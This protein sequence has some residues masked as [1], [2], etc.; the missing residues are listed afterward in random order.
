[1]KDDQIKD[2]FVFDEADL[3]ANRNGQLSEKQ[4][5]RVK[6]AD[7]FAERVIFILFFIFL[8]GGIFVGALAF[9][10][11]NNIGLWIGTIT[12][13]LL[14]AW[15]Y[16]G[17]GTEVDDTVQNVQGEVNFVKVETKTGSMTAPAAQR[18]T[19]SDYEMW[20]GSEVFNNV[21]PA[22]IEVMDG[23]DYTVYFT[24]ITRQILSIEKMSN[25]A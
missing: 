8:I 3:F 14:A 15:C 5:K 6:E 23:K 25:G 1:M 12:L 13:L 9:Y 20:V 4:S 11:T 21:N 18:M 10:T 17:I 2:Y 7:R 24:K 16:R 22:L 19:V